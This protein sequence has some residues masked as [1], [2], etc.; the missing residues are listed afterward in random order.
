MRAW[1]SESDGFFLSGSDQIGTLALR[2][3]REEICGRDEH[4]PVALAK[5]MAE[6]SSAAASLVAVAISSLVIGYY[7]GT[8]RA[9]LHYHKDA[10]KAL[11]SDEDDEDDAEMNKLRA[12]I[13]DECK[14]V[15]VVRSDLKMDKG[16]I[17]AQCSHAT[18][19]CYKA[20][21]KNNPSVLRQWERSGQAKVTLK[22]P[23]EAELMQ[24]Q[25]RAREAHL[26]AESIRDAYVH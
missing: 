26:C 5:V 16:K 21:L 6:T 2:P 20:M 14:L 24:L 1:L 23:S 7:L 3:K 25:S 13:L 17:A 22:C 19:A 10:K 11:E 4:L 8:G 15:L 12:G 18:L 9:L